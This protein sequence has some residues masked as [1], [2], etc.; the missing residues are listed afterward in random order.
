MEKIK[1]LQVGLGKLGVKIADYIIERK[2][3]ELVGVV[4]K[5]KEKIGKNLKDI[6]INNKDVNIKISKDIDEA[7][8]KC[9]PDVVILSTISSIKEIVNQIEEIAKY[10]KSI[11]STCEELSYPWNTNKE[12]ADK[13]D[14]IAKSNNISILGTGVNPGFL[15]DSLPIFLTAACHKIDSIKVSRIQDATF[16]RVP[17]QKKI[18]AGLTIK[19]FEEK[20]NRGIIRHVGLVE[21][22][23]MIASSMNWKLDRAV[24]IITPVIA[25]DR[26]ETENLSIN[27]GDVCGIQQI[28][29]GYIGKKEKI[30]LFF[31]AALG[32]K[33]PVDK[34]VIE[35]DPN[36]VFKIEGG[37]NGDIATCSIIANA[38]KQIIKT[39]PGLKCM[40]DI[41]IIS[42]FE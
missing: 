17:F 18:G 30:T 31:R 10:R 26:I 4:D 2:S 24:D 25:K 21:S 1:V 6:L 13:I 5:D 34:T 23:N 27:V 40:T 19:Q 22:I 32:E 7:F 28:G 8:Q 36:L 11:V 12:F 29:I 16:R 3:L 42:Y 37:L 15:M 9:K 20:K 14:K 41:P 35:G 38:I 33:N 39:S